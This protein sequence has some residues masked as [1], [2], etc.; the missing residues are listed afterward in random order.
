MANVELEVCQLKWWKFLNFK[1][2][3]M[4]TTSIQVMTVFLA[5]QNLVTTSVQGMTV[6]LDVSGNGDNV[7]SGNGN[8]ASKL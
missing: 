6:F 5:I 1:I 8:N 3:E 7:H 2:Q 4:L